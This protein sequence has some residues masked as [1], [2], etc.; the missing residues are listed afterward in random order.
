MDNGSTDGSTEIC[1]ELAKRSARVKVL[2]SEKGW[3]RAVKAGLKEAKGDWVGYTNSA[4]TSAQDLM[5][6]VLYSVLYPDSAVKAARGARQGFRR[7]LGTLLYNLECRFFFNLPTWDVNGTPKF[8]P[9]RY[10][11]LLALQS[12]NDLIDAEFNA[13][14]RQEGYP[15]VEVPILSTHRHSGKSTTNYTSAFKMYKGA[16]DLW[17]K[18]KA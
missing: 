14:C 3:G 2:R 18:L 10:E 17:R 11:K 16:F 5:L 6:I 4:R 15:L 9:R 1:G 12:D 7:R 13:V 8:F